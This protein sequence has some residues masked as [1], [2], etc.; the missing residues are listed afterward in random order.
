MNNRPDVAYY[1]PAPYW[2]WQQSGW[3]KS[4]LLFFD[5]IAILLPSY[6]YGRHQAADPALVEPLKDL[7]LLQVL[8]PNDWVDEEMANQLAEI[9]VELLTNGTFDGLPDAGHLQE[10]SQSRIGYGADID[11]AEFLVEELQ[12]RGLARPSADGVSIRPTTS[13][14]IADQKPLLQQSAAQLAVSGAWP[15]Q[16]PPSR[17]RQKTRPSSGLDCRRCERKQ[18]PQN[19]VKTTRGKSWKKTVEDASLLGVQEV[20]GSNPGVPTSSVDC[21]FSPCRFFP[22]RSISGGHRFQTS[23]PSDQ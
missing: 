4:L 18:T 8:E 3:V 5:H 9:V 21:L 10:L 19:R 1:Y 7:G 12:D 15:W 6:M 23:N 16:Q 22:I 11:L 17:N 20:P 14:A 2:G 13:R